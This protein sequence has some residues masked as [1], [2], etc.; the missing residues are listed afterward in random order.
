M[1]WRVGALP[2]CGADCLNPESA[3]SDSEALGIAHFDRRN[4]IQS[5]TNLH[6]QHEVLARQGAA[7]LRG[8]ARAHARATST[9][10]RSSPAAAV[11]TASTTPTWGSP[12]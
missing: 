12:R 11:A 10:L 6:G 1:I 9:G 3:Y 2:W 8:R 7:Q 4:L 5:M